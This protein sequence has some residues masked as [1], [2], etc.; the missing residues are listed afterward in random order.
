MI[1]NEFKIKWLLNNGFVE[2]KTYNDNIIYKYKDNYLSGIYVKKHT[3]GLLMQYKDYYDGIIEF[4]ELYD[5][6]LE[7]EK[8][9][10]IILSKEQI[11]EIKN[12]INK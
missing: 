3:L 2:E 5:D 6:I 11:Q 10:G 8:L 12:L 1:T 7:E 9:I 4:N